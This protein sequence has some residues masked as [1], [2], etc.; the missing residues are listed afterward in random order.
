MEVNA[1]INFSCTLEL[2]DGKLCFLNMPEVAWDDIYIDAY[3]HMKYNSTTQVMTAESLPVTILTTMFSPPEKSLPKIESMV[4]EEGKITL[5]YYS[6][7][8]DSE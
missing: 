6:T 7:A 1:A 8:E 2:R 5:T 4:I 3:P